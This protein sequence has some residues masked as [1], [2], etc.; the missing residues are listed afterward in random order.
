M[1]L[2]LSAQE[3]ALAGALG[4]AALALPFLFHLVQLG[5]L[6]M[7]M[8][9]PLVTLAFLVRPEPAAITAFVTPLLS[10]V[11]TGMPPLF[12][13]VALFMA[14]E[15]AIMAALLS[16]LWRRRRR[17]SVLLVLA[18]VL[19]LGRLVN[20]GLVYAFSTVVDLPAGFLAGVS[21]S[22]GW[23]GVLLMLAVVPGV[24]RT[25][26]SGRGGARGEGGRA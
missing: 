3:L 5:S 1:R 21:F 12:P 14:I 6:F 22:S 26:S 10:A 23:P 18:P 11:F 24:V 15:L 8:Y 13:P 4:A 9:A 25:A 20:V 7:P 17:G 2:E 19:V 16:S